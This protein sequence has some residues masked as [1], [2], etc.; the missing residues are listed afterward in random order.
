MTAI[1]A[2][3]TAPTS[4]GASARRSGPLARAQ[5]RASTNDSSAS[6]TTRIARWTQSIACGRAGRRPDQQRVARHAGRRTG[7]RR[8]ASHAASSGTATTNVAQHE[9]PVERRHEAAV[10]ERHQQQDEQ[11]EPGVA[12]PD[13]EREQRVDVLSRR[14]APANHRTPIAAITA[15]TRFSGRRTAPTRPL[16]TND[17]PTAIPSTVSSVASSVVAVAPMPAATATA[18]SARTTH[19][20]RRGRRCQPLFRLGIAPRVA[21]GPTLSQ[22]G[23]HVVLSASALRRASRR[24]RSGARPAGRARPRARA[25]TAARFGSGSSTVATIVTTAPAMM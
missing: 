9:Q 11:H 8:T 20:S 5:R 22:A 10:G 2:T 21:V 7:T 18:T 16:S 15:P 3:V 14:S 4:T 19:E 12:E 23:P 25:A 1:T 24:A 13:A 17:Q 6:E